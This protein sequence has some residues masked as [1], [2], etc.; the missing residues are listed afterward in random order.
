MTIRDEQLSEAKNQKDVME[1]FLRHPGWK[2]I[3]EN[4]DA[5][6]QQRSAKLDNPLESTGEVYLHE[7]MKG[8][9]QSF[10]FIKELPKMIIDQASTTIEAIM[11]ETQEADKENEYG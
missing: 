8:A 4:L 7:Y 2:M 5:Q 11:S 1:D 10:R 6:I 3:N 9:R